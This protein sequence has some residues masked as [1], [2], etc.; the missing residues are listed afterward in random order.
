VQGPVWCCADTLLV[1]TVADG[2]LYCVDVGTGRAGRFA[3]TGGGPNGA[4]RAAEVSMIVA[5]NGD[6]DLSALG[7]F[8]NRPLLGPPHPG[9]QLA[10]P[11]G[12]VTY[13]ADDGF[14]APN[15][16]AVGDDGRAYTAP[17]P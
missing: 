8:L 10:R 16:L 14:L 15:D 11:D 4:A 12:F 1:T 17:P 2:A 5:Q 3:D 7:L 9:L 13:L 6:A